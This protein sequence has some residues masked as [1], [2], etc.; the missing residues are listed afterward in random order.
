[1]FVCQNCFVDKDNDAIQRGWLTWPIVVAMQ[2]ANPTQKQILRQS[3]GDEDN[4]D[5]ALR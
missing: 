5:S 2:F 1:M 4:A 3:Y